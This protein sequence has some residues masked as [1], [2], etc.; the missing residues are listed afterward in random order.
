MRITLR[1]IGIGPGGPRQ[2]TLQ[3]ID[4]MSD[5]D[6]FLALEKG[7]AKSGLLDARRV[8]LDAHAREGVFTRRDLRSA[9]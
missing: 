9:A 5:V 4:A 3:A 7:T 1:V 8:I 6:V 2:I